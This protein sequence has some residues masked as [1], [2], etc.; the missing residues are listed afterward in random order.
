MDE[1][2]PW[3]VSHYNN[4]TFSLQG[5]E[6]LFA[7]NRHFPFNLLIHDGHSR[8]EEDPLPFLGPFLARNCIM[9]GGSY[10]Y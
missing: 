10:I 9:I 5:M 4:Y 3:T 1:F 8:K 2:C 7:E 6:T